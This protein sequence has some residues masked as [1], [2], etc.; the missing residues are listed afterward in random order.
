MPIT[1]HLDNTL[2][3]LTANLGAELK[4]QKREDDMGLLAVD[5][6]GQPVMFAFPA[7]LQSTKSS[8]VVNIDEQIDEEMLSE[9]D[10]DESDEDYESDSDLDPN[11]TTSFPNLSPFLPVKLTERQQRQKQNAE[12][13]L[14][15]K[16]QFKMY[17]K[18]M[19]SLRLAM[20]PKDSEQWKAELRLLMDQHH[21]DREQILNMVQHV[22]KHE[23]FYDAQIVAARGNVR[24][25]QTLL[26]DCRIR[27]D[28]R[29]GRPAAFTEEDCMKAREKVLG[30]RRSA[31]SLIVS[32]R[33]WVEICKQVKPGLTIKLDLSFVK[34]SLLLAGLTMRAVT[35]NSKAHTPQVIVSAQH[36]LI[37]HYYRL[38]VMPRHQ[39]AIAERYWEKERKAS[40]VKAE[41][42]KKLQAEQT[43]ARLQAERE[44]EEQ[45]ARKREQQQR[46]EQQQQLDAAAKREKALKNLRSE[47]ARQTYLV[48]EKEKADK[49][50]QKEKEAAEAEI[51]KM[52]K[53]A[54]QANRASEKAAKARAKKAEALAEE[55]PVY[56][57]HS[58][59]P[60]EPD[61]TLN[62]DETANSWESKENK[63]IDVI[64]A[65][66]VPAPAT[67]NTK[68][69][70]T[71]LLAETRSGE[72]LPPTIIMTAAESADKDEEKRAQKNKEKINKG[73]LVYIAYEDAVT[74]EI[75]QGSFLDL[76]NQKAWVC[77]DAMCE[78]VDHII[79][80]FF[81]WIKATGRGRVY[82]ARPN[83]NAPQPQPE[84][85]G[86]VLMDNMAA[87]GTKKV[88][89]DARSR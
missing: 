53:L 4:Q 24:R 73:K 72:K 44:V 75:K 29:L 59:E 15:K 85:I 49:A 37:F 30:F 50:Q 47:E 28:K 2:S 16:Q 64:G 83:P 25:L 9:E 38:V 78:V 62:L 82:K 34:R 58:L 54:E 81:R 17:H 12:H 43:E 76:R 48:K 8:R 45:E 41:A 10:D 88:S 19:A 23:S 6:K 32:Q 67:S 26:S 89:D 1:R 11:V 13:K 51:Q 77:T 69:T 21:C 40:L 33:M 63:T 22:A 55:E 3:P 20:W 46:E 35:S 60:F 27:G 56:R 79:T 66:I 80:P 42:Q 65:R 5:K 74:H 61:H 14:R 39:L 52:K 57:H 31:A 36:W 86:C 70:F 84:L 7:L 68:N 18:Y 87:H 71:S